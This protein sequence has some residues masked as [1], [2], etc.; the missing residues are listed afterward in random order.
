[1][2]PIVSG[3]KDAK[4]LLV[5]EAPGELEEQ[6]RLPFIGSSGMELDRMLA[7]SGLDRKAI[8]V[9]NVCHVRPPKNDIKFFMPEAKK[10]AIGCEW[11]Y[12][13]WYKTEIRLGLE[14]L[15]AE[16]NSMPNLELII[17]VGNAPL[18]AIAGEWGI[19]KWRGSQML[20]KR[21]DRP[22]PFVPTLHPAFILRQW[23]SRWI[24]KLDYKRARLWMEQRYA[25]PRKEFV[26]RPSYR[27]VIDYLHASSEAPSSLPWIL[28]HAQ[29]ISL[30][31]VSLLLV[32]LLFAFQSL[33]ELSPIGQ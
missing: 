23:S 4:I 29:S 15:R 33:R 11:G 25:F 28:R 31:L 21:L 24:S 7:E 18:W 9:T 17:G 32:L 22:I 1:M 10:D 8:R 14:L 19:M 30:V 6:K 2:N 5:G 12:G 26:I 27:S 20:S 3:P 16:V 13:K